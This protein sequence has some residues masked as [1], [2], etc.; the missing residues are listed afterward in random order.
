MKRTQ[1]IYSISPTDCNVGIIQLSKGKVTILDLDD[2]IKFGIYNWSVLQTK[3]GWYSVRN[4]KSVDKTSQ[5]M[6]YLHR[7]IMDCPDHLF[8]DHI[9]GDTLNNKKNNLRIV[10]KRENNLNK[11]GNIISSSKYKGV[12]WYSRRSM[13][14]ARIDGI[15]IGMFNIEEE[16]ALAYD[17]KAKERHKEFAFLNFPEQNN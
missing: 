13:W 3:T 2:A 14:R 17:V 12:S 7:L 1:S 6:F 8:V 4:E 5:K 16:A 10:T 9:N 15:D 11:T